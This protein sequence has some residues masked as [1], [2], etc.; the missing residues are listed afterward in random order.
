MPDL[1]REQIK[2]LDALRRAED[3]SSLEEFDDET[4]HLIMQ[5]FGEA[6]PHLEAYELAMM[7][8]AETLVNMPQSAQE[9]S[10]QDL[11]PKSIE[12]RRQ[13]LEGCLADVAG[14]EAVGGTGTQSAS[15]SPSPRPTGTPKA[16]KKPRVVTGKKQS[17]KKKAG[18]DGNAA[19]KS[20]PKVPTKTKQPARPKKTHKKSGPAKKKRAART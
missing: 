19:K 11:F 7:G 4:E 13:V 8:E 2:K 20:G 3:F 16:V 9:D 6:S 1:F 10:T 15:A 5:R 18:A 14:M 12:Q 17:S